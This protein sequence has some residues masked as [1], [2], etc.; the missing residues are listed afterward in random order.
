MQ[1]ARCYRFWCQSNHCG[2]KILQSLLALVIIFGLA[3]A[4][5]GMW[6]GIDILKQGF[7]S[8]YWCI[9]VSGKTCFLVLGGLTELLCVFVL[10]Y[11]V[12]VYLVALAV[13]ASWE[14]TAP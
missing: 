6:Y 10:G 13:K 14:E 3:C 9:R 5:G 4:F 7:V 8:R 2:S 11:I 1:G 12:L